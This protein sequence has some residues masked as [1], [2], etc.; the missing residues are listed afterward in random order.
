MRTRSLRLAF[1]AMVLV[2]PLLIS[3]VSP[4]PLGVL[5][6]GMP[7]LGSWAAA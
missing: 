7:V 4:R 1:L 2:F 3:A 5:R 6:P